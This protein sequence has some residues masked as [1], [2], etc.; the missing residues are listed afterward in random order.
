MQYKICQR[1]SKENL[2]FDVN[3]D[4]HTM[5]IKCVKGSEWALTEG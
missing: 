3:K 5:K 4:A 1:G 2:E